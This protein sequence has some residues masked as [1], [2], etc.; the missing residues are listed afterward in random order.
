[1]KQPWASLIASG[2]KQVENRTYPVPKTVRGQRVAIHAGKGFDSDWWLA[3][4]DLC[5]CKPAHPSL[6]NHGKKGDCLICKL[7]KYITHYMADSQAVSG[8]ILCTARIVGQMYVEN[9]EP[10]IEFWE[11]D[12]PK[13]SHPFTVPM[14]AYQVPDFKECDDCGYSGSKYSEFDESFYENLPGAYG[15]VLA[16][17]ELVDDPTIHRGMLGFW[18]VKLGVLA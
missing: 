6:P 15:W 11:A 18:E 2:I 4:Y 7:G 9:Q 3:F 1:M 17:V 5:Q 14:F 12:C 10:I 16:D 8:R 13:C